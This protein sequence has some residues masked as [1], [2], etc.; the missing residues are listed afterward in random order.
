MS[1]E[2]SHGEINAWLGYAQRVG[3][4][5]RVAKT[6][7]VEAW[8]VLIGLSYGSLCSATFHEHPFQESFSLDGGQF[9]RF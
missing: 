4:S 6:S 1:L 8:G 2:F 7:L 3:T 5:Y 9:L